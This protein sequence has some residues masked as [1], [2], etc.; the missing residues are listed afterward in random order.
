MSAPTFIPQ[1]GRAATVDSLGQIRELAAWIVDR[2]RPRPLVVLTARNHRRD[3]FFPVAWV[4]ELVGDEAD[5]VVVDQHRGPLLTTALDRT[6]PEG[7]VVFNGAARIFWPVGH[8]GL[9]PT[10][11]PLVLADRTEVAGEH[12]RAKLE[13]RWRQGADD[14]RLPERAAPAPRSIAPPP[15]APIAAP[16]QP[17]VGAGE[18]DVRREIVSAWLELLPDTVD[19]NRFGLQPYRLSRDLIEQFEQLEPVRAPVAAAAARVLSGYAWTLAAP[20]PQRIVE[21]DGTPVLR[22]SD[23]A[24]SWRYPLGIDDWALF[25]WQPASAPISLARV[26]PTRRPDEPPASEPPPAAP[27]T[28]SPT[29]DAPAGPLAS[30]E[31]LVDALRAAAQPLSASAL[32]NALGIAPETSAGRVSKFLGDA[33]GRGLMRRSGVRGGTRYFL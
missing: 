6:L 25:Y 30:D 17:R 5:V 16:R 13:R 4:Q 15:A 21:S 11:H 19:R 18:D 12:L 27:P 33:V 22:G 31:D 20:I 2:A 14:V 9:A 7:L 1:P 3:P 23:H 29:L 32:R 8:V 28:G 10:R 26:G 24:V